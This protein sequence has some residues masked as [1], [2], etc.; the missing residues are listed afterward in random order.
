MVENS[1]VKRNPLQDLLSS[2][3]TV[4]STNERSWILTCHV[5]FKLRSNQIYELKTTLVQQSCGINNVAVEH[6]VVGIIVNGQNLQQ[7]V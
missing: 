7:I 3:N 1:F 6:T 2:L 4:I 5:I